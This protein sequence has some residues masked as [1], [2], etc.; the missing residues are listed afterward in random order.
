MTTERKAT[1]HCNEIAGLADNS[2]VCIGDD[3]P[4]HG[5]A[6]DETRIAGEKIR[7]VTRGDP[8]DDM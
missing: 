3:C 7:A 1:R 4:H 6:E 5:G 2:V 8:A